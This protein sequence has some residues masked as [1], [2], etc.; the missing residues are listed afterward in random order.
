MRGSET[1][2]CAIVN[3][4]LDFDEDERL[5]WHNARTHVNTV[6]PH[7]TAADPPIAEQKHLDNAHTRRERHMT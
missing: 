6:S 7:E 4:L 5:F 1:S 3:D 2:D